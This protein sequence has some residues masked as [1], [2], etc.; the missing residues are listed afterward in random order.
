V[1]KQHKVSVENTLS[2]RMG[3]EVVSIKNSAG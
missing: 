3:E 1:Y 2:G